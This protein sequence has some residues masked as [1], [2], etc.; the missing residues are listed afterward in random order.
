MWELDFLIWSS[1][2][3]EIDFEYFFSELELNEFPIG[4]DLEDI[5]LRTKS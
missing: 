2:F 5:V 3:N 1:V 4:E